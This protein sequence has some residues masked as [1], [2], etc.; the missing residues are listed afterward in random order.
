M[1]GA[2]AASTRVMQAG[3]AVAGT[4]GLPEEVPVALVYNGTTQAVMMATPADLADFGRGFTVTEGLAKS[5][6]IEEAPE[7]VTHA[8]GIEVRM[9]LPEDRAAALMARRRATTGPVGC[10]LC[11]VDSLDQVVRALPVVR[12]G[13]RVA[14]P[15]V[16][17]A[18]A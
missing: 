9:W 6:E 2:G 18:M 10:G 16:T 8:T 15:D 17:R 13:V 7:V 14:A 1:T 4:R 11:G 5:D 12:E 3:R